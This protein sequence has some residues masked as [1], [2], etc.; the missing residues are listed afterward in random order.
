MTRLAA[1][2][3]P[4]LL[5]LFASVAPAGAAPPPFGGLTELPGCLSGT[6]S[7]G[8]CGVGRAVSADGYPE[9]AMSPDGRNVYISAS[10]DG[11]VATLAIDS[12]TGALGQ[13][14]GTAGCVSKTGTGGQCATSSTL[15]SAEGAAVSPDGRNVYVGMASNV[16]GGVAAF[17]RSG[18]SVAL[19]PLPGEAACTNQ[20]GS[21]GCAPGN[22]LAVARSVAISPDGLNVYVAANHDN[23]VAAFSRDP[24]TG[25]L[26]QLPGTTGCLTSGAAVGCGPAKA[27]T[28]AWSV[29]VSPDGK[30]V[31]VMGETGGA[32][33]VFSRNA[34]TGAL[35]QLGGTAG[36]VST[37]GSSGMCAGNSLVQRPRMA[38]FSPDGGDM[39]EADLSGALIG[40]SRSPATR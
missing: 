1:R 39:Y 11:A 18:P 16:A 9:S 12:A 32:I 35:T 40:F 19:T 6:G 23:A 15:T 28:D 7:G 34:G 3:A 2:L 4:L 33:A 38:A 29:A 36:C 14:P 13:L 25:A 8:V 22:G 31:Y 37:T 17:A 21:G 27:L 10:N 20:N 26:T 5:V 30:N 24:A